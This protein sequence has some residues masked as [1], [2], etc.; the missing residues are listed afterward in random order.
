ME[1]DPTTSVQKSWIERFKK[2]AEMI[3][4]EMRNGKDGR[5]II[6]KV[7]LEAVKSVF[8]GIIDGK[9]KINKGFFDFFNNDKKIRNSKE[10]RNWR[11]IIL[12]RDNYTC[13]VCNQMEGK[14]NVDHIKPFAY[15]PELRFE[16]LNGR[17]LCVDCH[18]KTNTYGR[19]YK[20]RF[21]TC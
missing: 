16:L 13:Q 2:T 1:I 19:Q 20:Y 7:D 15:F 8:I 6:K 11:G 18:K 17:T 12:K 5:E 14:L 10:Y 9:I 21:T 3:K 4:Y